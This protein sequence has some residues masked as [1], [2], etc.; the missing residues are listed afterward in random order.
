MRT[1]STN[2]RQDSYSHGMDQTNFKIKVEVSDGAGQTDSDVTTVVYDTGGT[3][4]CP[5]GQIC[6]YVV[7]R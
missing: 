7:E 2:S 4:D 3:G 5:P 1:R 6:E